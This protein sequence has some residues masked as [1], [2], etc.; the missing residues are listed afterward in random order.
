MLYWALG[1]RD[2]ILSSLKAK[3]WA[4]SGKC[5]YKDPQTSVSPYKDDT[6]SSLVYRY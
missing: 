5:I 1:S 3:I 2:E 4:T 6:R